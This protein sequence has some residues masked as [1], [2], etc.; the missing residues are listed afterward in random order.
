MWI[1]I[2]TGFRTTWNPEE[3]KW[4]IDSLVTM[5]LQ[6][7]LGCFKDIN[8]ASWLPWCLCLSVKEENK[9]PCVVRALSQI[10]PFSP[11]QVIRSRVLPLIPFTSPSFVVSSVPRVQ[12][13]TKVGLQN[14]SY[15]VLGMGVS[16]RQRGQISFPETFISLFW[17]NRTQTL[18]R[19]LKDTWTYVFHNTLLGYI[20]TYF[21][22][23][24]TYYSN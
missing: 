5:P 19:M 18:S 11:L 2:L 22:K 21:T 6:I 3:E 12:L 7:P 1:V 13:K 20:R 16:S 23:G 24:I 15:I 9:L 17:G 8:R 4:T 10:T 14:E